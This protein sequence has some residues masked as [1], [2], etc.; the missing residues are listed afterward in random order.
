MKE[1]ERIVSRQLRCTHLFST[2][3]ETTMYEFIPIRDF[4]A[5]RGSEDLRS[6]PQDLRESDRAQREGATR[7]TRHQ[8]H[9]Y[10]KD[11]V[12]YQERLCIL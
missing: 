4:V 6:L 9:S 7:E 8:V 1:R 2:T 10:Y 12:F 3:S 11:G 5:Y